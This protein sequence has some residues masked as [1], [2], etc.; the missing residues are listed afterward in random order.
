MFKQNYEE[1]CQS[2]YLFWFYESLSMPSKASV[3][4]HCKLE[5]RHASSR[6]TNAIPEEMVCMITEP[7]TLIHWLNSMSPFIPGHYIFSQTIKVSFIFNR[8]KQN[9]LVSKHSSTKK[10]IPAVHHVYFLGVNAEVTVLYGLGEACR[11]VHSILPGK[12][13]R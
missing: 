11:K 12:L 4:F 6:D 5:T 2:V 10:E 9:R 7:W 8:S 3:T 13:I 1:N